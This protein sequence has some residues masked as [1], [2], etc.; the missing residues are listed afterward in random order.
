M[1]IQFGHRHGHTHG[2]R[3]GSEFV[4]H[5]RSDPGAITLLLGPGLRIR[6][7]T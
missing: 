3:V 7:G 2:L 1:R 6:A 5:T 4:W